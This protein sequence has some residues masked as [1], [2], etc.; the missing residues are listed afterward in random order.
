MRPTDIFRFTTET[1]PLRLGASVLHVALDGFVDAGAVGSQV[2]EHVGADAEV[3]AEFDADALHDYRSRR[4]R[5]VFERD[6]WSGYDEPRLELRRAVDA[7]GTPFLLL[8]GDE[9]DLGWGRFADAVALLCRTLGVRRMV[10]TH[11]IPMAVPHTRPVGVTRHAGDPSTLPQAAPPGFGVLEVPGSADALL[12]LRLAEHGVE[13]YGVVV[14]VP[15]YIADSPYVHGAVTAMRE[16]AALTDLVLPFDDLVEAA[17]TN[18]AQIDAGVRESPEAQEVIGRLEQQYDRVLE[19]RRRKSL[20]RADVTDLPSAEE[21]GAE[22]EEFLRAGDD[23]D[24]GEVGERDPA[25]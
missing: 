3:I 2:A 4:P 17:K 20:L 7:E 22:L 21:I 23:D 11:G 6:H 9:P 12:H 19:G 8:V 13:T 15:H 18:R 14:H 1:D 16:L 24:G 5:M 25:G 10:S